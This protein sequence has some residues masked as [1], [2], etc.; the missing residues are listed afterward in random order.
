M[1][2]PAY[3]DPEKYTGCIFCADE[4]LVKVSDEL[5]MGRSTC[6]AIYVKYPQVIPLKYVIDKERWIRFTKGK[7]GDTCEEFCERDAVNFDTGRLRAKIKDLIL[8]VSLVIRPA[9]V[10]LS[11]SDLASTRRLGLDLNPRKHR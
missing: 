1:M 5:D 2:H 6:K 8:G 7:K 11:L 10:L 9:L 4:Y 3:I